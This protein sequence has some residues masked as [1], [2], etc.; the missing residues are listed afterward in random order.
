[1]GPSEI[2]YYQVL[3]RPKQGVIH[4]YTVVAEDA[5]K[6]R[7]LAL[8]RFPKDTIIKIMPVSSQDL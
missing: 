5:F 3:L 6:A 8:A 2:T 4:A 1:M 7:Q